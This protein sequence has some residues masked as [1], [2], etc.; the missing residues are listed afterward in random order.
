MSGGPGHL[1]GPGSS[2]MGESS[3]APVPERSWDVHGDALEGRAAEAG[4]LS[5]VVLR[6]CLLLQ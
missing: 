1:E 6:G 2:G 4:A 5:H 3:A